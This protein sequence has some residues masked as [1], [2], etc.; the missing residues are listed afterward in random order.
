MRAFR[1]LDRDFLRITFVIMCCYGVASRNVVPIKDGVTLCSL[2]AVLGGVFL[3]YPSG[4]ATVLAVALSIFGVPIIHLPPKAAIGSI[5]A[6]IPIALFSRSTWAF[7]KDVYSLLHFH[8]GNISVVAYFGVAVVFV[9][10]VFLS[11]L[12][13]HV[14]SAAV[15]TGLTTTLSF[16]NIN[17]SLLRELPSCAPTFYVT[18]STSL[19]I[20][21]AWALRH[22]FPGSKGWFW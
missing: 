10:Q 17:Q 9:L 12:S 7:Y 18:I 15:N 6:L 14:V 13:G 5:V 11:L 2:V 21:S 16:S 3:Y 8:S 19:A 1:R 4:I 22:N 20:V